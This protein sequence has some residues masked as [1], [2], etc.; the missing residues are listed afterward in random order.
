MRPNVFT[1]A[2]ALAA[3]A[4]CGGEA[5]RAQ[6]VPSG[7]G[8]AVGRQSDYRPHRAGFQLRG[9]VRTVREDAFNLHEGG[10]KIFTG[11]M[12]FQFDERGRLVRLLQ[13]N[14]QM[15]DLY[16]DRFSYRE[17]GRVASQQRLYERRPERT[18]M[19]VYADER[20]E[21][22]VLTYNTDG[23]L[24]M[25]LAKSFDELGG[26]TRSETEFIAA[27]GAEAPDKQVSEMTHVYDE[28]GRLVTTTVKGA[29]GRPRVVITRR[30]EAVGRWVTTLKN[31][32]EGARPEAATTTTVTTL[33]A[34]GELLSNESYG[35]DGRLKSK[36]TYERKY[37]ARGN[38][39]E[40]VIR[41]REHADPF[42]RES[43]Y[44]RRRTITYF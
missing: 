32:S 36:A 9:P 35:A 24:V 40:E 10:T 30:Q 5:A 23:A 15:E 43:S 27:K 17:D 31:L 34:R 42:P 2:F 4:L 12:T 22:E 7:V 37:D 44:L 39:V 41:T 14:N 19:F 11:N 3:A 38:W 6:Y 16:E 26:E 8:Q 28:Q 1:L 18:E 20:R 13:G 33:D 21:V 25:R 29:D